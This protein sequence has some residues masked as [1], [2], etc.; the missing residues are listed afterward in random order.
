MSAS[1]SQKPLA[2]AMATPRKRNGT[3]ASAERSPANR[4]A[5][6]AETMAAAVKNGCA[7]RRIERSKNIEADEKEPPNQCGRDDE[8][9]ERPEGDPKSPEERRARAHGESDDDDDETHDGAEDARDDVA[10]KRGEKGRGVEPAPVSFDNSMPRQKQ[11]ARELDHR[12]IIEAA[13][14]DVHR[15]DR[16]LPE[17]VAVVPTEE[18]QG[19]GELRE[20]T[21]P[22]SASIAGGAA[23]EKRGFRLA[24]APKR[25]V[26]SGQ[27]E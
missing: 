2:V 9:Q 23:T 26:Y 13:D 8:R 7:G 27:E 25:R 19:H 4:R 16:R 17:P 6:I 14:G 12:E 1:P 5:G 22:L 11:G 10:G 15:K 21:Y 18:L 20:L 3:V 24:R